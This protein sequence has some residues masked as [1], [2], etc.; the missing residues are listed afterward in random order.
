MNREAPVAA[1]FARFFSTVLPSPLH[2]FVGAEAVQR[3]EGV[4]ELSNRSATTMITPA[5]MGD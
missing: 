4:N 2:M 5:T 1:I 3:E